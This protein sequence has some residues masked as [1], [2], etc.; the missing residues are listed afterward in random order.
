MKNIKI[1]GICFSLVMLASCQKYNPIHDPI[2]YGDGYIKVNV[3]TDKVCYKPG[4]QVRFTLKK[5]ID[6][7]PDFMVRYKHLGD[8]I[9]DVPVSGLEWTWQPPTDDFKGYLADLHS[10]VNGK[11]TTFASIAVDVSSDT[12]EFV[13]NGFLSSYGQLSE[14]EIENNI[15]WLRRYHI[16]Y[17]QFQEWECDHHK[18]VALNADGS[19]AET[20]LDIASRTNYRSTVLSYLNKANAAGMMTLSYNLCYGALKN[21][22]EDGVQ[23]EWYM[24]GDEYLK[25]K[26]V[27]KLSAPFKSSIFLTNPG[28]KE[29]QEYLAA[30]NQIIYQNYPFGGYQIDQLGNLGT[31]YVYPKKDSGQGTKLTSSALYKGFREF[32]SAMKES[33]P[34]KALVMNAVSQFGQQQAISAVKGA[35]G[36]PIVDFLYTEVW[37]R[38]N[39]ETYDDLVK[40]IK[41]N[42]AMSNGSRRTVLAAYLN[43]GKS[44]A[45]GFF[46]TPGVLMTTAVAQAFGG[47]IL[48]MGEHMLCNEYFPNNNLQMEAD[49]KQGIIRYYDFLVAY[50]NVLRGGGEFTSSTQIKS[51]AEGVN[52]EQ[53][54]ASIRNVAV[55]GKKV[56]GNDYIHFINLKGVSHTN[57]RDEDGT[58]SEP[59]LLTN[60]PVTINVSG[61][62]AKVWIASPD[63]C[64]GVSKDLAFEQNGSEIN[65]TIPYLKYWDMIAIEY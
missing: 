3:N 26:L 51:E 62:V 28:D 57:W 31:I 25:D 18:P 23:E 34:N 52:F 4:E 50:E 42:D 53:W 60:V 14:D 44:S 38:D 2:T 54:P 24:F 46:N 30:Q 13:R 35:D 7:H 21:A 36:K 5:P 6:G 16:N 20:W 15:Y 19:P 11:D 29:W 55:Q 9:A 33:N 45:P 39:G 32:I 56:D 17:L 40:I 43:Y 48:Q 63:Y 64:N 58:Q 47:T 8:V 27:H 37:P 41:S 49:L 12:R 59:E 65:V 61:T 1:L 10:V 22:P